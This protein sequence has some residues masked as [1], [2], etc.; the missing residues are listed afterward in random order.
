MSIVVPR[1]DDYN[2]SIPD[3]K[4]AALVDAVLSSKSGGAWVGVVLL[5]AGCGGNYRL[6]ILLC[7]NWQVRLVMAVDPFLTLGNCNLCLQG[8][9]W[10]NSDANWYLTK[11]GA[12][13][14][15]LE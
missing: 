7:W 11:R 2:A 15:M 8:Y 4:L 5:L 12:G 10:V 1:R 9:D 6:P 3:D 14:I 13:S